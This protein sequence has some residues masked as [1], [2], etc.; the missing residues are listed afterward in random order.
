MFIYVFKAPAMTLKNHVH[1][2]STGHLS[3]DSIT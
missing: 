1:P 3:D 2:G